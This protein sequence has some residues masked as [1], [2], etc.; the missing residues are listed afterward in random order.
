MP[1]LL[2]DIYRR[3][4]SRTRTLDLMFDRYTLVGS[5]QLKRLD[6]SATQEGLISALWQTWC[7][8]CRETVIASACGATSR[9]GEAI[10]SPYSG[11]TEMEIAYVARELA[12]RRRVASVRALLGRHLEPTWGDLQKLNLI[13]TGISSTNQSQLLSAFGIGLAIS[14]LQLCRNVSAHLNAGGISEVVAA[15]VRYNETRFV[16]PS[17]LIFWIDPTTKDFLWKTWIDEI[18]SVAALASE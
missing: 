8:F 14:D 13:A 15:R 11:R 10:T 2:E 6:R 3:L 18:R 16:H 7:S 5:Q 4:I 17:D 9:L 1:I 12:Y